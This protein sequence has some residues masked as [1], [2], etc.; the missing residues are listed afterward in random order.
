MSAPAS[1]RPVRKPYRVV[2][3]LF[4][5][6]WEYLEGLCLERK[7]TGGELIGSILSQYIRYREDHPPVPEPEESPEDA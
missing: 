2:V 3:A 6:E 1:P 7:I 5:R 4:Q